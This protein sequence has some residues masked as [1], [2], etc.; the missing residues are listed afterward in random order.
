MYIAHTYICMYLYTGS[1]I[2]EVQR[3]AY[4]THEMTKKK[5]Q[6]IKVRRKKEKVLKN[7]VKPI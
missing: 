5:V 2:I 3:N 6:K 1:L 7:K 4:K